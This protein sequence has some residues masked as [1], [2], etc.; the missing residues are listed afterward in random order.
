MHIG[1]EV[2]DAVA[3]MEES[4]KRVKRR[5]V[6]R[7]N[8]APVLVNLWQ[9]LLIGHGKHQSLF[10]HI[11]ETQVPSHGKPKGVW[12]RTSSGTSR[13]SET[14]TE[15]TRTGKAPAATSIIILRSSSFHA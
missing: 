13:R 12:R 4:S 2:M 5:R 6:Q 11:V 3:N 9:V 14:E 8:L 1:E 7:P 15:K 10:N